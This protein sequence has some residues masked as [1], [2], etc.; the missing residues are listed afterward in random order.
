VLKDA[1][2]AT[3]V[4][5]ISFLPRIWRQGRNYFS[6]VG[7]LL[8]TAFR[9]R[10]WN[11]SVAVVLSLLGLATQ[12]AAIY[13]VYWYG[14]QMEKNGIV[15]VPLLPIN[16]N[17][18]QQPEWLWAIVIFST[19]CL[20][21]SATLTYLSRQRVLNMVQ[22]HYATT[23]EKLALLTL[24]LPD[25]RVRLASSLFNEYAFGGLSTGARRGTLIVLS[26][27][28]ALTAIIGGL[29]AS[30]FLLR[31]DLPLTLLILISSS[32]AALLLY[33]LT[34]RAVASA[35]NREKA[36]R[37][38]RLELREL[39]EKR[40]EKRALTDSEITFKGPTALAQA[41]LMRRRVLTEFV[42]A[43][44]VGITVILGLVIYYTA[45]KAL[46]GKEQWAIFIAYIGALRMALQGGAHA[47]QALASVSRY[48]PQIV[49]YVLFIKDIQKIHATEFA[50]VTAGDK[51][52]LGTL[53]NGQDVSAEAG[54]CMALLSLDYMSEIE[55]SLINARLPHSTEPISI[56]V[57]ERSK[58]AG[59]KAP[60]ALLVYDK[61]TQYELEGIQ[62]LREGI[63]KD[64]V[65]LIVYR[66]AHNIGLFGEKEVLVVFE[67]EMLRHVALGT[68]D[69]AAAVKEYSLKAATK[70]RMRNI[71][72]SDD[73]DEDED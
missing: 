65:A 19:A 47:V 12:A 17:L 23:L 44:E 56:Q 64:K 46:A 67:G 62:V 21:L 24:R 37:D 48:Y 55:F 35:K 50:K 27:V 60:L 69:F 52:I 58:A 15:S 53:A 33:P 71:L 2:P 9:G 30:F 43:I 70:R 1:R 22:H 14:R 29:G 40:I 11:L 41:F 6:L 31:I 18:K 61:P 10:T 72:D 39:T 32:L 16:I 20:I 68:E 28:T 38:F 26:S 45:S 4:K 57:V 34:L 63:L 51:V 13:A 54:G 66:E 8:Y 42:Y 59:C 36:Q 49:R 25:P 3:P 73:E 5:P 7:W